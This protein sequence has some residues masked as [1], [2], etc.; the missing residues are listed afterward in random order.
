MPTRLLRNGKS[1]SRQ[2]TFTDNVSSVSPY[3]VTECLMFDGSG[4]PSAESC[5]VD[6][7]TFESQINTG[8]SR[9]R[10]LGVHFIFSFHLPFLIH[11]IINIIR[12]EETP[13]VTSR[14]LIDADL[15]SSSSLPLWSL[16]STEAIN[17][18]DA[19]QTWSQH[20]SLTLCA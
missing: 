1:P 5:L 7:L 18:S 13:L 16:E 6:S 10:K 4:A 11:S 12:P 2:L 19:I 17:H 8:K 14:L 3:S 9:L 20:V 15:T